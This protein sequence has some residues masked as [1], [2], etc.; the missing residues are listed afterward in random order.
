MKYLITFL[1]YIFYSSLSYSQAFEDGIYF[2]SVYDNKGVRWDV[3]IDKYENTLTVLSMRVGPAKIVEDQ[4]FFIE[5]DR[6]DLSEN[7]QPTKIDDGN[8]NFTP[9]NFVK[10]VKI[11]FYGNLKKIFKVKL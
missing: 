5:F 1:V 11:K 4:S 6:L 8:F 3:E 2:S 9:F 10:G 7:I